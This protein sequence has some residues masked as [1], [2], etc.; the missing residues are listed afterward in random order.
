MPAAEVRAVAND[1]TVDVAR[2]EA[3]L[4]HDATYCRYGSVISTEYLRA[5]EE[6]LRAA[7]WPHTV[8]PRLPTDVMNGGIPTKEHVLP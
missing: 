3:A 5:G 4:G 7:A 2:H 1:I 8:P 6:E